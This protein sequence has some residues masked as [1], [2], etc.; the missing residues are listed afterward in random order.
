[1]KFSGKHRPGRTGGIR[2]RHHGRRVNLSGRLLSDEQIV[3]D[4]HNELV[5]RALAPSVLTVEIT[6]TA[7]LS[8]RDTA[9]RVLRQLRA[10]GVRIEIDELRSRLRVVRLPSRPA[11]RRRQARPRVHQHATRR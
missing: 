2:R 7:L 6:E 10:M 5:K 3:H 8:D 4:I 9:A 1:M 11:S